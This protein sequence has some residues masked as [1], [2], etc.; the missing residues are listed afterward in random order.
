MILALKKNKKKR[1]EKLYKK[2]Q[3]NSFHLLVNGHTC[4][5]LS[6]NSKLTMKN[7]FAQ[8]NKQHCRKVLLSSFHLNGHTLGFHPQTQKL[9][10]PCTA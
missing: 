3:P 1:K 9:E 4:I 8:Q 10:P 7:H 2:V 6:T 5:F